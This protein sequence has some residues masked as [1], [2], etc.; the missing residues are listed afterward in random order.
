MVSF[1]SCQ[2]QSR[3]LSHQNHGKVLIGKVGCPG[4]CYIGR[5]LRQQVDYFHDLSILYINMSK[6]EFPEQKKQ[7]LC[8]NNKCCT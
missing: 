2:L 6:Q 1:V 4:L 7:T 8:K 5:D 3:D